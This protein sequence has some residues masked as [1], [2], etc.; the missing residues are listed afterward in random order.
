MIVIKGKEYKT[1]D[2]VVDY[3]KDGIDLLIEYHDSFGYKDYGDRGSACWKPIKQSAS[4]LRMENEMI[5]AVRSAMPRGSDRLNKLSE[6][7]AAD[8]NNSYV[9]YDWLCK[10][11]ARILCD[12]N[13]DIEDLK[14]LCEFQRCVQGRMKEKGISSIE[15]LEELFR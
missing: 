7:V 5:G 15:S 2:E 3:A 10:A 1:Y 6:A 11:S 12:P 13:N 9:S 8:L 14:R 4:E